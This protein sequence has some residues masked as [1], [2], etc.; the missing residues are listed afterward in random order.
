MTPNHMPPHELTS[1]PSLKSHHALLASG[2]AAAIWV[3]DASR[4]VE[5]AEELDAWTAA[6]ASLPP[7][8]PRLLLVNKADLVF[9]ASGERDPESARDAHERERA[10][11]ERFGRGT[12]QGSSPRCEGIWVSLV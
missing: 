4:P 2:T 9:N 12:A 5:S 7:H 10:L 3:L 8:A 1:K 11:M 6:L